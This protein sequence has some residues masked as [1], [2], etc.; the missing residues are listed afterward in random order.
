MELLDAVLAMGKRGGDL[1]LRARAAGQAG[2][3][4]GLVTT[5]YE[6]SS[7]LAGLPARAELA[8]YALEIIE[9]AT[10]RG[11]NDPDLAKLR[12]LFEQV[13]E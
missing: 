4:P 12:V 1:L 11:A 5:L 2:E 9:E 8:G 13:L 6:I 3:I 10:A 7:G